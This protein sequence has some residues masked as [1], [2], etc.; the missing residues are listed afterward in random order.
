MVE[1]AE[2]KAWDNDGEVA[3]RDQKVDS[4]G[5]RQDLRRA[6]VLAPVFEGAG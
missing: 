2:A 5:C 4:L 3:A 6:A 1:K